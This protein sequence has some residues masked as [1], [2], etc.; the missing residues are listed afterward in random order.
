MFITALSYGL[1][2][3]VAAL[4]LWQLNR[5][6]SGNCL[7]IIVA[8]SWGIVSLVLALNVNNAVVQVTGLDA[9]SNLAAPITEEILKSL[10]L[11]VITS[12]RKSA[13]DNAAYG[14]TVGLSFAIA[15]NALYISDAGDTALVTV[16]SR[17][18]ST[19]LMHAAAT[20]FVG[21]VLHKRVVVSL[22]VAVAL[23]MAFNNIVNLDALQNSTMLFVVAISIGLGSS[24]VVSLYASLETA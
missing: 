12:N 8:A 24:S 7:Y 4:A 9:L 13:T 19:T 16:V 6:N 15:E 22:I 11:V 2:V 5:I 21:I 3:V 1:L 10:V 20:A 14:F 23:H 18:L 17:L